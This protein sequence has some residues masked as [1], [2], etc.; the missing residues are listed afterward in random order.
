MALTP[1]GSLALPSKRKIAI[2]RD[3]AGTA[4]VRT[5]GFTCFVGVGSFVVNVT[6]ATIINNLLY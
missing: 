3:T 4:L 1:I 5:A 2:A 6:M